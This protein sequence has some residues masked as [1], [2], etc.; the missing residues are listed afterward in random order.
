MLDVTLLGALCMMGT[1]WLVVRARPWVRSRD[2]RS[3]EERITG[4]LA[5]GILAV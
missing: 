3:R 5:V 4:A 1:L 2:V